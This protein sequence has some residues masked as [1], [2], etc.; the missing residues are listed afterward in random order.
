MAAALVCR[1]R[2]GCQVPVIRKV[3]FLS[4]LFLVAK[5]NRDDVVALFNVV[6][7]ASFYVNAR[8]Q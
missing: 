7:D 6:F 1:G 4:I 8:Y 5:H 2:T 3:L